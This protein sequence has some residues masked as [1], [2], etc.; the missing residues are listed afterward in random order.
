MNTKRFYFL[1]VAIAVAL[2]VLLVLTRSRAPEPQESNL[3]PQPVMAD[4]DTE[5]VE[6]ENDME[7]QEAYD[8]FASASEPSDPEIERLQEFLDDN[9][10]ESILAQAAFLA[11]SEDEQ[12][13]IE[14]IDAL[15][16]VSTPQAAR[17][18]LP[19]LND[20]NP[21]IA[22]QALNGLGHILNT[23]SLHINEDA[24]TGELVVSEDEG[25]LMTDEMLQETYDLWLAACK[26][27]QSAD[28]LDTLLISLSGLDVKFCVPLLVD[29]LES[30]TGEKHNVVLEHLDIATNRDGV[31]N[32]EEAALWLMKEAEE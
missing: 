24:E 28:D 15:I 5:P 29:V 25:S 30:T 23:I 21:E 27:A 16:W 4:S 17:T 1:S 31:T 11:E 19:L 32:R 22:A 12:R 14:A 2:F 9:D 13:R 7:M 10:N 26:A 20:S 6:E 3:Q 8:E 18:L